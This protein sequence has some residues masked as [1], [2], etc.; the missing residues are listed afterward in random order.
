MSSGFRLC[1]TP[2]MDATTIMD[3]QCFIIKSFLFGLVIHFT[4]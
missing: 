2:Q 3:K 4:G 1:R